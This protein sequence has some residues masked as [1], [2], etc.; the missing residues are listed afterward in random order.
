MSSPSAPTRAAPRPSPA[1]W[2]RISRLM[3]PVGLSLVLAACGASPAANLVTYQRDWPDGFHEEVAV[4]AD[5]RVTMRHGDSL[6]RLTLSD[7]QLGRLRG[8]LTTGVPRGDYGDSLV[9]TVILE[10]AST[11]SPV[12]P[13]PDSVVEMLETLMT[14]HTLGGAAVEGATPPPPRSS[15][16]SSPPLP[17]P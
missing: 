3:S 12:T 8:A 6:E 11:Y 4:L 14:T 9:R 10:D 13:E 2:S 16:P 5:G 7:E 17:A 1:P 15:E